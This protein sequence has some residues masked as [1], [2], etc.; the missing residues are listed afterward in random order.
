[1]SRVV[2]TISLYVLYFLVG[3]GLMYGYRYFTMDT[4]PPQ[5]YTAKPAP[6]EPTIEGPPEF[7]ADVQKALA[8]LKEKSPEQYKNICLYVHHV[9][10]T[11]ELAKANAFAWINSTGNVY[12]NISKYLN[13]IKNRSEDAAI[14]IAYPLPLTLVHETA[15]LKQ[16]EQNRPSTGEAAEREALAAERDLLRALNVPPEIID[17]IVTEQRIK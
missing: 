11:D 4:A 13:H 6:S 12:I 8:F 14:M 16:M 9:Q 1:M 17:K 15:H 10:F 5:A 3:A 7:Q 2:R